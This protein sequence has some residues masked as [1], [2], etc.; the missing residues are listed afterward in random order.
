MDL[1][2]FFF[3]LLLFWLFLSSF[4]AMGGCDVEEGEGEEEHTGADDDWEGEEGGV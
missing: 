1:L 3:L 4:E 2:D